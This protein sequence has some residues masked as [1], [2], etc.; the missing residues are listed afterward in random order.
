MH[1]LC[2][3]LKKD[4]SCKIC[5]DQDVNK[6]ARYKAKENLHDLKKNKKKKINWP[7]KATTLYAY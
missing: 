3:K 4:V 5:I 6:Q 2:E 1:R 7:P